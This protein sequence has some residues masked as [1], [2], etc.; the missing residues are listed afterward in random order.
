MTTDHIEGRNGG[1]LRRIPKGTS[2]N[3]NGRPKK[4]PEIDKLLADVLGEEKDGV[5]AA[6]AILKKLRQMASQGNLR[7]A[8]ILL[9]RGYGKPKQAVDMTTGGDKLHITME[10]IGGG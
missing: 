4:L 8:E 7:A 5:S 3:P 9:D 2:G 6:E 10:V 1:K